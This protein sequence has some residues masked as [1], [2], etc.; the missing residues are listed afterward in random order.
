MNE[1]LS[2]AVIQGTRATLGGVIYETAAFHAHQ[3]VAYPIP[4]LVILAAKRHV[5][6]LDEL[7]AA[8]AD[9]FIRAARQI[10]AAQ[11]TALADGIPTRSGLIEA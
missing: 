6:S 5:K 9:D 8:E 4:G 7:T 1:C 11:R 10:R 3:D 2:C